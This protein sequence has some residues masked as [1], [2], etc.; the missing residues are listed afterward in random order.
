MSSAA[1]GANR[2]RRKGESMLA[3]VC[4][5]RIE[6]DERSMMIMMIYDNIIHALGNEECYFFFRLAASVPFSAFLF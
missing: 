2:E 4:K 3:S 1:R 5:A 6:K